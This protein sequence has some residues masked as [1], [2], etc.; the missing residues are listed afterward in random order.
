MARRIRGIYKRGS[1]WWCCYVSLSGRVVRESTGTSSYDDAVEFLAKQKAA[2]KAGEA[3]EQAKAVNHTF[4]ELSVDYLVW[5]ER[6][7]SYPTKVFLVKQL[8]GVFGDLPLRHI[9]TK[10]IEQYQSD[11]IKK[12]NKPATINRH[13]ATLKHMMTKAHDWQWINEAVARGV[14]KVKLLEE[15]NKRLRFLSVEECQRLLA[16]CDSHLRPIV[17]TALNTGMRK[18]EILSLKWEDVDLKHGF[19]HIKETKNGERKE[20]PIN[21]TL[22]HTLSGLPRRLDGGHVFY[23]PKTDKPYQDVKKSFATACRKAG[24]TDFHFH[25]LRHT[26]A[27][28]L[29]MAGVDLTTVKELLGHKNL[30]MTLRYSHLSPTHKVKAVEALDTILNGINSSTSQLLHNQG[31]V[32]N[33]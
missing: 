13:V 25:D 10:A 16:L 17:T 23:D 9:T 3:P 20:V 2:V 27:S 21:G 7:R 6:Q 4:K 15:N 14:K 19:L 11:R 30:T 31:N 5:C 12:G 24:I 32:H 18:G 33:G 22:K 28:H 1:V 29:V 26:Y 8:V